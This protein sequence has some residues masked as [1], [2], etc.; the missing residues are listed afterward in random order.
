MTA[1]CNAPLQTN[2]MISAETFF[3]QVSEMLSVL[4][5]KHLWI[6][7]MRED[8]PFIAGQGFVP[9]FPHS[10]SVPRPLGGWAK[11]PREGGCNEHALISTLP[12]AVS[13]P[14]HV[15][16]PRLA[17]PSGFGDRG[18]LMVSVMS[19][20]TSWGSY[21]TVT[22]NGTA[23]AK[24]CKVPFRCASWQGGEYAVERHRVLSPKRRKGW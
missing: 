8:D 3:Q 17:L 1:L 18:K 6:S 16:A 2:F 5:V 23:G 22:F 15:A 4:S 14:C 13:P 24:A 21:C 12:C 9:S 7:P 19:S 10:L 20:S 11:G